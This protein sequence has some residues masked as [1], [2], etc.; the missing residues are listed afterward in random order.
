MSSE[1]LEETEGVEPS[2]PEGHHGFRD[3]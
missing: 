2:R 3:R 1:K